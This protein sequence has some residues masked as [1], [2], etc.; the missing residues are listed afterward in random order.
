MLRFSRPFMGVGL[1]FGALSVGAADYWVS[2]DGTGDGRSRENPAGSIKELVLQSDDIVRMMRGTHVIS[3]E[4][5]LAGGVTLLGETG[6][7]DDVVLDAQQSGRVLVAAG[8]G[9]LIK[10]LTIVN[11]KTQYDGGGICTTTASQIERD[12]RLNYTVE[13][14]VVRDCTASYMGGAGVGGFW[15]NC[16]ISS[17]RVTAENTA[18]S[19][20][21][22]NGWGGGVFGNGNVTMTDSSTWYITE[23]SNGLTTPAYNTQSLA[24]FAVTTGATAHTFTAPVPEPTSGLLLLLG[25]AGFALKR[26]RA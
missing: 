2:P 25:V 7:R 19:G 20:L 18:Y 22:C 6:N 12:P 23:T 11:G 9:I 13:N 21:A 17:C 4:P 16:V 24:S 8:Q 14:C 1:L 15:T 26:R 5:V 10:D 3:G